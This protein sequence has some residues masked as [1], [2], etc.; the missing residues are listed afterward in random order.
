MRPSGPTWTV[1]SSYASSP[2]TLF[3]SFGETKSAKDGPVLRRSA[4]ADAGLGC[5]EGV[6][7]GGVSDMVVA[8]RRYEGENEVR[9]S[10]RA[11][12]TARRTGSRM[13]VML[14]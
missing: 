3:D 14:A 4:N 9:D 12:D 2:S 7:G 5:D 13:F 10:W 8:K 6:L 1:R 11:V